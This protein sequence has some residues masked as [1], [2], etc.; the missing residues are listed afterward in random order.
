MYMRACVRLFVRVSVSACAYVYVILLVVWCMCGVCVCVF[1]GLTITTKYCPCCP[2]CPQCPFTMLTMFS[3]RVSLTLRDSDPRVSLALRDTYEIL[4]DTYCLTDTT[5]SCTCP[6]GS[7]CNYEKPSMPLSQ[8]ISLA[9]RDTLCVV[10]HNLTVTT[11]YCPR[12][13]TEFH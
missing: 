10:P 7:H 5:R 11:K 9:L 4:R 2:T 3:H 1:K 6:K 12:C 8:K 13:P